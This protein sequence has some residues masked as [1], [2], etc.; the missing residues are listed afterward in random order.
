MKITS[1]LTAG[2]IFIFATG[3]F[4]QNKLYVPLNIQKNYKDSTRSADGKPG[5]KYWQNGSD[6]KIFANIDPQ[7]RTLTGTEV[8][9]YHNNS[10]ETLNRIV[11]RNYQ[12]RYKKGVSR[13]FSINP[14]AVNGGVK[15][16]RLIINDEEIDLN[17]NS[18]AVRRTG[19]LMFV[20]L[21][22]SLESG[23][24]VV[25]EL[26]WSFI[27]PNKSLQRM[28][29]YDSTSFFIAY[30]YPQVSVF[31]DIDGWDVHNYGGQV[32]FYNDFSNYD[33]NITVPKDFVVWA[34]GVL[35]NPEEI[36]TEKVLNKYTTA[37]TSEKVINV[38]TEEDLTQ[39]EVTNDEDNTYNFIAE[40]VTDFTF[41]MSDHYLW[42]MT[43]L[44][45]DKD[46]GRRTVVGSAYK[47]ESKKFKMVDQIAKDAIE[48]FSY[49]MPAV[50][51]P[52]PELTVFNGS[53]GMESP[54]MVNEGEAGSKA[55]TVGVTSHEIAHTYFP[56]YMGIN[57]TKY[58][59]MDEGWATFLPTDFQANYVEK[60]DP[61]RRT[62][63]G[64]QSFAGSETE[65]PLII[66]SSHLRGK[67]YRTSAYV[68]PGSAYQILRNMLG[69]KKFLKALH[70]YMQSWQGKHP[71][72]YDFFYSFNNALG[73]NLDWFW[74]PWF[75]E[76]GYPDLAIKNVNIE[77]KNAS[78]TVEKV[79]IIPIPIM[80]T[81]FS[82]EGEEATIT[83]QAD[84]WSTGKSEVLLKVKSDNRI[85][86]VVLGNDH[87]P[88][89]VQKNNI[90]IVK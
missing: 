55:G 5:K 21:P 70:T 27:I 71:I 17:S 48:Y 28:G 51:Y 20:Q 1:L 42:D 38:I 79:G 82:K 6:Y 25:L 43:S 69:E 30:W 85:T 36:F 86:K 7:T 26:S 9:I 87:I 3:L 78:I 60:N 19:T 35:Q 46:S 49:T 52:Y 90:Y 16:D 74:K 37:R 33:V 72:P 47:E 39:K 41:G 84:V 10:P 54:M 2:F 59:F 23:S 65:M 32:E 44:V 57:E 34:T 22:N 50:P 24:S 75:F 68:R 81:V 73:E 63:I 83:E 15:I 53:G 29:A 77:G 89:A 62:V 12:D 14:K 11:M 18:S 67:T 80:I 8:I 64:Y 76:F 66:P 13:D 88:D 31:D 56:F 61:L 58:A 40:N 4:A 45:V